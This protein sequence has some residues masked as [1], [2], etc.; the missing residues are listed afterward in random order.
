MKIFNIKGIIILL[1]ILIVIQVSFA[2]IISPILG[3]IVIETINKQSG[4]KISISRVTV[5]PLTLSCSLNDLKVFDPDNEKERIA[6]IR[7]ASLK[8]S[9]IGLLSKRLV[10]S[11]FKI[12]GAEINLKSEPDGSF[13]IQKLVKP[14]EAKEEPARKTSIFDRFKQKKDLFSK[15]YEIIKQKSSKEAVEEKAARQ[16]EAKKVQREVEKLPYGRRVRFLKPSDRYIFEIRDFTIVDSSIKLETASGQTIDVEKAGVYIKNLGLDP[17]EGA[18]FDKLGARGVFSKDGTPSGSFSLDYAQSFVRDT[19]K[20][21]CDLSAKNVDLT[22]VKTI[23]QDSLP[24]E[25]QKGIVSLSSDTNIVNGELNSRNSLT[26]KDHTVVP[27]GGGQAVGIIPL[28]AVCDALNK[29]NPVKMKFQITGT[30]D[31]PQFHGFED[32][33]MNLIKPYVANV[34][35]DLAKQGLSALLGKKTDAAQGDAASGETAEDT[36]AKTIES[37]KSLFGGQDKE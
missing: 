33:L 2:L 35:E 36:A 17:K 1:V 14:R 37:L 7:S 34:A 23:Y 3:P 24:I 13:N 12:S 6:L 10:I 5:W 32:M 22:A 8:L 19:Q 9:P 4:T 30:V 18:R 31:N 21:A 29:I 15:I 26:L 16:K 11:R 28:P 27:K 25:F 20:I